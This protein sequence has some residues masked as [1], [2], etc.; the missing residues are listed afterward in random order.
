M[1]APHTTPA[2]GFPYNFA[3]IS[4]HT[5]AEATALVLRAPA[6]PV[7]GDRYAQVDRRAAGG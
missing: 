4:T 2:A 5:S 6:R 3:N 1:L 7:Y